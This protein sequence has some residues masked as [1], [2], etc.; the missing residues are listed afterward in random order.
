[1]TKRILSVFLFLVLPLV[2]LV[3]CQNEDFEDQK[4]AI[5]RAASG[6]IQREE[7]IYSKATIEDDFDGNSVI[8]VMDK[9]TGGMNKR[10]NVNFFGSFEKVYVEDLTEITVDVKKALINE[11]KFHQILMIKLPTDSKEN[12]LNVIQKLEK[13]EGVLYAGP[14]YF[15]YPGAEPDDPDYES[16]RQWGLNGTY[17]IQAPAAWDITL[18]SN[19]AIVGVRV[20][21]IDTGIAPHPDLNANLVKGRNFVA[22]GNVDDTNDTQGHGTHCAGIVGAVG[23]NNTGV[24]GVCWNVNLV[25]LKISNT[26]TGSSS[27]TDSVIAAIKYAENS[28]IPILNLSWW[29]FAN[30]IN[31][32]TA[33]ANYSGLFV[34]I[35]G[36]GNT[37]ID[38]N[39]NYPGSFSGDNIITVGAIDSNGN[40]RST[41]NWGA[42]SVDLFAPG[43]SIY[44]T[45]HTGSYVTMSGTSM[46]AP[47]VAGVAALIFSLHPWMSGAELKYALRYGVDDLKETGLCS[48]NG[49]INAA[50][51]VTYISTVGS[52]NI[53]FNG[54]QLKTV[55][56]ATVG[57][58][59]LGK[60]YLFRNNTWAI[61]EMRGALSNPINNFDPND[62]PDHVEWELVPVAITNYLRKAQIEYIYPM[63]LRVYVPLSRNPDEYH[64][65][66][67]SILPEITSTCSIVV[68]GGGRSY[69]DE[70]LSQDDQRKIRIR[71]TY[72]TLPEI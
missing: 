50:I 61:V 20:G 59:H 25:P 8:L 46:A 30:D 9:K 42:K 34:C 65:W 52:M 47:H 43:G 36:N 70:T 58:I 37:D 21:I 41:S 5:S 57:R 27:T 28:N 19:D 39:P 35:A 45:S 64:Y 63:N 55:Q 12:V 13:I 72:G 69:I 15:L 40:R 26:N 6:E 1:M 24:S 22:G 51:A 44:S 14:N 2:F 62:F 17:G 18:G 3:H 48:T 66:H 11:E 16:G 67:H 49:K 4:S 31:L 32:K 71:N 10:H 60:F 68:N 53:Y 56:G 33:I 23:N 7:K 38:Q 54:S 29:N